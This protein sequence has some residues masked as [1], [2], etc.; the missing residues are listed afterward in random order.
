MNFYG[1]FNNLEGEHFGVE[2]S[3]NTGS[4]EIDLI[5]SDEP[6]VLK[7]SSG[8]L[9]TY[10]KSRGLSIDIVSKDWYFDLYE[11]TSRG[12]RVKL[13]QYEYQDGH[14]GD[15]RYID[16]I[17]TI[18]VGYLTPNSYSQ[19]FTYLDNIKLEAVDAVSTCKDFDWVDNNQYNSFFDI[20]ISLLREAGYDGILYVPASYTHING[21]GNN[22]LIT[23]TVID[24]LFASSRNFIDDNEEHTPWT[25]YSVLEEIMKFL[26]WSLVPDGED[27]W[28]IDY[29]AENAG[30]V[31]YYKYYIENGLPV[32]QSPTYISQSTPTEIV[33]DNMAPGTSKIDI[34]DIYNKIE[35]SDNLYKIDEISPDIFDDDNHI[36]IT[37]EENIGPDKSKWSTVRRRSFLWWEWEDKKEYLEGT[38]YQTLCR[39]KPESGWKHIYY[40]MSDGS[41]IG[42]SS[43]ELYEKAYHDAATKND[44][45]QVP[46]NYNASVNRDKTKINE[47]INTRCCLLQH[48]AYV[49]ESHPNNVPTSI[50]WTDI[51]TFFC[52]GPTFPITNFTDYGSLELPVLEYNISETIQWK[53]STG[54]SWIT[55]NGELFYQGRCTYTENKK[56]KVLTIIN[57]D[58]GW[59]ATA[60]IDKSMDNMPEGILVGGWRAQRLE[61]DPNYGLG[62]KMWKMK[63]QIG[64]KYWDG[65]K[66]TSTESTFYLSYNNDPD[67]ESNEYLPAF[68]WLKPVSNTTFKDQVGEDCYAI[69]IA[70]DDN[71]A[72]TFGPLKLT[73]YLPRILPVELQSFYENFISYIAFSEECA[74]VIYCKD[75]ELGYVYTDTSV[76]WNNHSDTNDTDKVYIGYIDDN[77]TKNFDNV[78][79]KLNTSIKDKPISRSYVSTSNGYLSTLKHVVGDEAKTQEY[80]I[81]DMY[82]DHHS[83]RKI[84][85][86]RNMKGYYLPNTKFTKPGRVIDGVL[87]GN[88]EGTFMIDSQSYDLR[89]NNNKIKFIAF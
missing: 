58:E 52:M 74:P 79:F 6:V 59:Y 51:L 30:P 44:P 3:T 14:E 69:P 41:R 18:F 72:P 81:V 23:E 35:I 83:E 19:D 73:I 33:L 64:D 8:G 60:P 27:V 28:L 55:I 37:E 12:I 22:H 56:T 47:I 82:L 13:Y 25:Q 68:T 32:T 20:V 15:V 78:E 80:N 10:I 75:F 77:Y 7:T 45:R 53:P 5:L 88:L 85:Y 66:W 40:R 1:Y 84:I 89:T 17:K 36:S 50:D 54:K 31:T 34:D 86:T 48:Y 21:V 61:S 29:R 71:A 43:Q 11:P 38:D 65:D 9:F 16:I 4:E 26:G 39:L 63:L 46:Y 49:D 67:N 87:E 2:I 42:D 57:T 70:A 76:W 24:K 62:F